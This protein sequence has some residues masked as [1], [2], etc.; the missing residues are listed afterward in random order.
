MVG[1]INKINSHLNWKKKYKGLEKVYNKYSD[2]TMISKEEYIDN[3]ILAEQTKNLKGDIVECGVWRGGM[4]AGVA[5]ILGRKGK[6]YL[7][8][9]FEGLPEVKEIDG[10]AA[11]KWQQNKTSPGYYDNCKAE[12]DF[13]NKAMSMANVD[14]ECVKGWFE[15]TIP[16]YKIDSISLLRLDADWYDST[17]VCLKHFY[18]KVV[19][20]GLIL[21]D[22]YYV[23]SGCSRAVHDYLSE[24]KSASRIF[25]S[26]AGVAYI[27]KRIQD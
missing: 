25:R 1:Y 13:A 15:N 5:D 20:N 22:D 12:I 2:F 10:A 9:S 6:Y 4:V 23:W 7:F 14:F 3:L 26:Q 27:V 17:M 11:K 8:D 18:P 16:G 21:I 19:E 24:T